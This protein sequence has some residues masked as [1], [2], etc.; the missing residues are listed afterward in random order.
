M[1]LRTA[2]ATLAFSL[3]A[4]LPALAGPP[5]ICHSIQIGSA[6][7]LP[8]QSAPGWNGMDTSYDVSHLIPD[9]LT[10]LTPQTPL[11]VRE[12]TLRRAALRQE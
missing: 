3:L 8:W 7:S 1:Y 6:P 11:A 2:I 4:A 5:L 10:L 12:E 9:T